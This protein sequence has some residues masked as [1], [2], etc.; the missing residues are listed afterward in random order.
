[1]S[2]H[3]ASA[4]IRVHRRLTTAS[5]AL[6]AVPAQAHAVLAVGGVQGDGVDLLA[7]VHGDPHGAAQTVVFGH[8][9][10]FP[11]AAF[12]GQN[13]AGEGER[14]AGAV[15]AERCYQLAAAVDVDGHLA[16]SHF[17]GIVHLCPAA[18]NAAEAHGVIPTEGRDPSCS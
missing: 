11:S 13:L 8:H 17:A 6:T 16:Q 12:A 1:M 2:A 4:F 9:V 5:D 10:G 3:G 7:L 14:A 15:G 18:P